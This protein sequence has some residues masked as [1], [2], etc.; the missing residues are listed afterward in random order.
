M[1]LSRKQTMV[2]YTALQLLKTFGWN[3]VAFAIHHE[4]DVR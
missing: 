2:I 4:R 3:D 1:K